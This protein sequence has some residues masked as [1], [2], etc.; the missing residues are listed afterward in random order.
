MKRCAA[1][2]SGF[3]QSVAIDVGTLGEIEAAIV[4]IPADLN[5]HRTLGR[6]PDG[7][8]IG[9]GQQSVRT[10]DAGIGVDYAWAHFDLRPRSLTLTLLL[11]NNLENYGEVAE[12]SKA[13]VC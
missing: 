8:T 9:M 7:P 2:R 3:R 6:H 5:P 12:W 1:R 4:V 10:V 11:K 13:R